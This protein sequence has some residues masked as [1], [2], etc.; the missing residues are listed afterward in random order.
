MTE[1]AGLTLRQV[2]DEHAPYIWRAMRHLGVAEAEIPDVCQ[3]VFIT[4][5]RKLP[6]FEGRSTLR[7]WLYGICLRVASD[8][9]RRAYVR[10][11]SASAEPLEDGAARTGSEPD[12]RAE[13]RATVRALL[14]LLDA[15]KR[16]VLVLYEIEG[17]TMKEVAEI[18]GCPL[19]T[20][21]SRL[22]A[23][24]AQLLEA[25]RAAEET[26]P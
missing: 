22:H 18:V 1:R 16:D 19:Q 12:T 7:T 9:R 3:E 23:A 20:A 15:D 8:H 4:V 25:A 11:E 26:E 2:F 10:R 21:Y 5:H 17:F 13:H 6:E 24:R 14:E